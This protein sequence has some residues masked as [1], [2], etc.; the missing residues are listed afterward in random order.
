MFD[1]WGGVA[2]AQTLLPPPSISTSRRRSW[3]GWWRALRRHRLG[4]SGAKGELRVGADADL[5]IADPAVRWTLHRDDLRDRHRLSPFAGHVFQGQPRRTILRGVTIALDGEPVGEPTG[6]VL[7]RDRLDQ[8]G[9]RRCQNPSRS[10]F[11]IVHS[12][13][14]SPMSCQTWPASLRNDSG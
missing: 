1:V 10:D 14:S 8:Q 11:G 6:R 9:P 3:R 12:E 5:V 13:P 4:L 2:G 7:R